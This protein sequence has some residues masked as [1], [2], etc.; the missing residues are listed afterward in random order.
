MLGKVAAG[1]QAAMDLGM[2]GLYPAVEHLGE[3]GVGGHLGH[4]HALLLQELG[5]AAGGEQLD[6]EAASERARSTTP[7][8][9]ET[10]MSA[11]LTFVTTL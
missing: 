6:A 10:L 1:E 7:D 3:A 5:G 2:Q 9:S 8:L 11:R 4:G